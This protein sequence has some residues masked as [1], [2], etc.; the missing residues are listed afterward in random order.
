[1]I[2]FI[3]FL[4]VFFLIQHDSH[5]C[6]VPQVICSVICQQDGDQKGVI[7][8]DQCFCANHRDMTKIPNWVPKRGKAIIPRSLE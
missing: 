6:D 5:S 3:L 8:K 2:Q 7:I 4:V 1:M